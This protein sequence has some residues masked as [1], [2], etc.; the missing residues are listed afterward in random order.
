MIRTSLLVLILVVAACSKKDPGKPASTG[1]AA[2]SSEPVAATGSAGSDSAGSGSADGSGSAMAGS[3]DGSDGSGAAAGS[4]DGSAAGSG[5]GGGSDFDKMSKEDKQKFMRENVVPAMKAA[6]QKFD[7]KEFAKFNCKT[8]HGKGADTKKFT[9]PNPDLP[10]LDFAALKAGKG[11]PKMVE[12][13]SK[14]VK[15]EMAKILGKP[16]M[17]E[18]NHTGFGCLA[19]HEMKK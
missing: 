12:F 8:C 15:P 2:G 16:E 9:M 18:T 17:T 1:S 11:D 10:K 14:V 6:F 3:A 13:M 19:C 7:G 4:G 5:S